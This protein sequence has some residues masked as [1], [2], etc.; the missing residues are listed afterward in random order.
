M[1]FNMI[2]YKVVNDVLRLR[3]H[4][5]TYMNPRNPKVPPMVL[6]K[7]LVMRFGV[8]TQRP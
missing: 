3:D 8:L 4:E 1:T 2:L 5:G 7:N 6:K